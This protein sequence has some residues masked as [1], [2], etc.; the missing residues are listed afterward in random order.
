M[1]ACNYQILTHSAV[2]SHPLLRTRILAVFLD[3]LICAGIADAAALAATG[4]LLTF[5][6][7]G[8]GAILW[9]WAAA[10]ASATA[11][12]LLRDAKGGRARRWLG[13]EVVRQDG[14]PPGR[15]AS[16]RRNLPLLVPG[17]NLFDAWPAL[18]D[19]EAPR[20]SDLRTGLRVRRAD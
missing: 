11:A 9:L 7:G 4:F 2:D 19:G 17:W 6:P 10:A 3:L 14:A 20:R 8:R 15:V 5:F 18:F 16:V 12:F 1:G 13:L